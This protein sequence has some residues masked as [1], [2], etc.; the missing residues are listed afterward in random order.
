MVRLA[1]GQHHLCEPNL[2]VG[3]FEKKMEKKNKRGKKSP[4]KQDDER[5]IW[6][7]THNA[8]SHKPI[9]CFILYFHNRAAKHNRPFL[10]KLISLS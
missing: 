4:E 2:Q 9:P 8:D 3:R 5:N 10:V 7:V 6:Q 1:S